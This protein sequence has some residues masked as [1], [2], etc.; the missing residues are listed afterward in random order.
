MIV[1]LLQAPPVISGGLWTDDD[2]AELVRLIKKY[3]P[4]ASERWERIA[5]AMGRSVPEV[6][7]M[8]AKVK[9]NCYKIPGQETAE[10]VPEPPK[11]VGCVYFLKNKVSSIPFFLRLMT[12]AKVK[13]FVSQGTLKF[14]P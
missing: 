12:E 9:E 2:L 5:E 11:K 7:H 13:F 4:G 3:P 1:S 8:A 14:D 10:E 6:T